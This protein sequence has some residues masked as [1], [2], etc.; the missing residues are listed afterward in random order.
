MTI[1]FICEQLAEYFDAPCNYSPMD[2]IMFK[3]SRC[4]KDCGNIPESEC[5]KRY[6]EEMYK[7]LREC[8][9]CGGSKVEVKSDNGDTGWYILCN[10]CNVKCGYYFT[11]EDAIGAWNRRAKK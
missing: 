4:E 8:P 2:E 5:W 9:F 1:D 3:D 7:K 6:F 10:E 11:K